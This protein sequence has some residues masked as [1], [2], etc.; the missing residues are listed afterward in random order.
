MREHATFAA[1]KHRVLPWNGTLHEIYH[2]PLRT[3]DACAA[4]VP[5]LPMPPHLISCLPGKSRQGFLQRRTPLIDVA[6]GRNLSRNVVRTAL[7][8]EQ[9]Q[10]RT[11]VAWFGTLRSTFPGVVPFLFGCLADSGRNSLSLPANYLSERQAFSSQSR[12]VRFS[13][14]IG[15]FDTTGRW[16]RLQVDESGPTLAQP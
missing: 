14:L 6:P 11:P 3:H 15:N 9:M 10:R 12:V 13:R 2:D 8:F 1:R 7:N 5:F 4:S 16:F